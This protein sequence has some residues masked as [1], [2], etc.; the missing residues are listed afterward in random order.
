[1]GW[2]KKGSYFI[3]QNSLELSANFTGI[4]APNSCGPF[5]KC[6]LAGPLYSQGVSQPS[7]SAGFAVTFF[8]SAC[9]AAVTEAGRIL[10]TLGKGCVPAALTAGTGGEGRRWLR[11]RLIS[12]CHGCPL[13]VLVPAEADREE[14]LC[15]VSSS[16]C[17]AAWLWCSCSGSC[18]KV[19]DQSG[20]GP[21]TKG[22][23]T[24]GGQLLYIFMYYAI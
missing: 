17:L 9:S 7:R 8:P 16:S 22:R 12:P 14:C 21:G 18:G 3:F 23:E 4:W 24:R 13:R 11:A 2:S 20:Q 10:G 1:M 19:S 6:P 15:G 5:E